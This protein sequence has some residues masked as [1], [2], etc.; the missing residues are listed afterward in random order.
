MVV[1]KDKVASLAFFAIIVGLAAVVLPSVGVPGFGVF[2]ALSVSLF[3]LMLIWFADPLAESGC[4]SRG[5]PHS[6]PPIL[7]EAIGWL[8]L[9][10]YP[11]LLVWS[12]RTSPGLSL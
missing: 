8:M 12:I 2:I 7:I 10:G 3:G 5:I 4:F 1:T 6:S 11:L 9:I